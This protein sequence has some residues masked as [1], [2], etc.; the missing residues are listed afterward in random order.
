MLAADSGKEHISCFQA[1]GFLLSGFAVM[2]VDN[3]VENS[4]DFLA[5]VDMPFVGLIRPVQ[6]GSDS[7]HVGNVERSPGSAGGKVL[8]ADDVYVDLVCGSGVELA[9]RGH[10]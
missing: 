1:Y 9:Q 6:T 8:A 3:A 5:I 10:E 4:K 2:H 7:A